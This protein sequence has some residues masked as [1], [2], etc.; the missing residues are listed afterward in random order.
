[1]GVCPENTPT[2]KH[3]SMCVSITLLR[4]FI[5]GNVYPQSEG[6]EDVKI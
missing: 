2:I 3:L 4:G 6:K 5:A 1:V